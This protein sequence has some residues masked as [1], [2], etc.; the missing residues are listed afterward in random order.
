MKGLSLACMMLAFGVSSFAQKEKPNWGSDSTNCRKNVALYSDYLRNKQYAEAWPF[1]KLAQ[2]SCP[3][4]KKNLYTNGVYI[5]KKMMKGMDKESAKPYVDTLFTVYEQAIEN[6]GRKPVF[7]SGYGSQILLKRQVDIEKARDLM[8]EAIDSLQ[9]KS[10]P[11]TIN[12]YYKSLEIVFRR[13]LSDVKPL[14]EEY[15]VLSEYCEEN[16]KKASNEKIKIAWTKTQAGMD[17]LFIK[18]GTKEEVLP[19][20]Q[21]LNNDVKELEAA[22]KSENQLKILEI[23][24]KKGWVR[25]PL[26]IEVASAMYESNPSAD[27]A[28]N[29][30]LAHA[31]ND[32]LK[33]AV[34]W[35]KKALDACADCEN[36]EKYTHKVAATSLAIKKYPQ[37]AKYG[38]KLKQINSDN[39]EAYFIIGV[40]YVAGG[41][42][43]GDT[44]LARQAVYWLGSDYMQQALAKAGDD[45]KK[46]KYRK[47]LVSWK[48]QFPSKQDLFVAGKKDGAN[49][50]IGCWIG[51]S[52]KVRAAS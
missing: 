20:L 52:T 10:N 51:E 50:N 8:K 34:E 7:L 14:L 28:Y 16:I 11:S 23:L 49:F 36:L 40:A 46:K 15:L 30:G 26:F 33:K 24:E 5:L 29:I 6:F 13:K 39:S 4:Y 22:A 42:K 35:F 25:E 45:A 12:Y 3:Q 48:K 1:W 41:T 21:T 44:K 32:E 27:A 47:K 19:V 38:K 37:A 2:K 17:A 9:G 18:Y 31:D 43:C